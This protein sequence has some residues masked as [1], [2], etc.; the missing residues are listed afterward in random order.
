MQPIQ[1][2]THLEALEGSQGVTSLTVSSDM[3]GAGSNGGGDDGSSMFPSGGGAASGAPG[4]GPAGGGMVGDDQA[5]A[6]AFRI[7]KVSRAEQE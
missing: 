6:S 5:I 7:L 2:S 1:A 3:D 4:S